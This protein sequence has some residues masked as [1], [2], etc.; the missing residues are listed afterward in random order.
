M[1][2]LVLAS[3]FGLILGFSLVVSQANVVQ[4]QSRRPSDVP[5]G[6]DAKVTKVIDGET[7][8]VTINGAPFTVRYLGIDAPNGKE[9]YAG[10]ASSANLNLVNGKR[11][12]LEQDVTNIDDSGRLLRYVYLLD[13]RMAQEEL[14]KSGAARAITAQPNI[15]NQALLNEYERQ[16]ATA[17]RGAWRTCKWQPPAGNVLGACPVF[18]IET[19]IERKAKLNEFSLLKEGDCVVIQKATNPDGP[20]WQGQYVWHPAGSQIAL[21]NMYVRWKD[22]FVRITQESDGSFAAR[23]V[24]SNRASINFKAGQRPIFTPANDEP[25]TKAIIPEP[26]QPNVLRIETNAFLFRATSNGKYTA[27]VDIFEYKSGDFKDVVVTSA[28]NVQ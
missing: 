22:G 10:Q 4:A 15:K 16:A 18:Q 2:K 5:A 9:C 28:G 13:G 27:L 3:T 14:A 20:A 23:F 25:T 24:Q 26:T 8:E 17:K 6:E 19:L 1:R 11:V 21:S 7:I 12:V